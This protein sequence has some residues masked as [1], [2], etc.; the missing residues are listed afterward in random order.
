MSQ[1]QGLLLSGYR[2]VLS[3][4]CL[5]CGGTGWLQASHCASNP[6]G[7][8]YPQLSG[9]G[10]PPPPQACGNCSKGFQ[11]TMV[12]EQAVFEWAAKRLEEQLRKYPKALLQAIADATEQ[13]VGG[14][15][16]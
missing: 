10:A 1:L 16:G 9:F 3:R 7:H 11:F 5:T 15:N 2:F 4:P 13:H 12:E 6:D 14:S 8:S